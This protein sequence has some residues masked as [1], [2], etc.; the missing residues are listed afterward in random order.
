MSA[1]TQPRPPW[2]FE[3]AKQLS[4]EINF[5]SVRH[6]LVLALVIELPSYG[7]ELAARYN[8]RF[9]MILPLG[10]ANIYSSL[11]QLE[12]YE[13]VAQQHSVQVRAA[14]GSRG[15][16]AYYEATLAGI[17]A[18]AAWLRSQIRQEQ[19]ETEL[20]A[21]IATATSLGTVGLREL[22]DNYEQCALKDFER[23]THLLPDLDDPMEDMR[24]LLSTL[25]G[26]ERR[27][28]CVAGQRWAESAR[29]S[30]DVFGR[31]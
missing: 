28:K 26:Q 10:A 27:L 23:A 20:L 8:Q 18:H 25:I 9:A 22:V 16:R 5:S 7:Y 13:L 29:R 2:H 31:R 11:D 15:K 12:R 19:W 17:N 6:W 30:I 1:D 4:V 3:T 21:R 24:T 14:R